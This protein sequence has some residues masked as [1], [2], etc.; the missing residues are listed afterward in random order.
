MQLKRSKQRVWDTVK[1]KHGGLLLELRE[2]DRLPSSGN[3]R[4]ARELWADAVPADAL[5]HV[6]RNLPAVPIWIV[7]A[8][9][10]EANIQRPLTLTQCP[11]CG[12]RRG[13]GRALTGQSKVPTIDAYD[14]LLPNAPSTTVAGL[15]LVAAMDERVRVLRPYSGWYESFLSCQPQRCV[16]GWYPVFFSFV[17]VQVCFQHSSVHE[18]VQVSV[19]GGPFASI[20]ADLG[21][22][23]VLHAQPC[24]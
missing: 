11:A 17:V 21:L 1:T 6:S 13:H 9:L 19:P 12:A 16:I 4:A 10:A 7:I 20:P 3:C 22:V 24:C 15:F 18:P 2:L 5:R 8:G 23:I 14:E